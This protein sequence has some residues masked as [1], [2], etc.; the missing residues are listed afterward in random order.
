MENEI[1]LCFGAHAD[2]LEIGMGGTIAKFASEGKRIISVI[3]TSGESS[4]PWLKED[5]IK[6]E[7]IREA[8]NIDQF[9]GCE[10]TIFIGI[11]DKDILGGIKHKGLKSFVNNKKTIEKIAS[12]IKKYKPNIIFTHSNKDPH[13]DHKSTNEIV[14]KS[15]NLLNDK[16]TSVYSFEVWNV[17]N[18]PHPRMY[19]DISKTFRKKIQ[20][21]KM[22]KSQKI[23][24]YSLF[25]QVVLRAIFSGFHTKSRFAER[26]YKIR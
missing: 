12:I 22:F 16:K 24:V 26:F 5:V 13:E 7:R 17:V 25:I 15:L 8:I 10:K 18:E 2:D 21:M 23:S 6:E 11:R 1:I 20:A 14:F 19:V 4:S 9:L 3:M